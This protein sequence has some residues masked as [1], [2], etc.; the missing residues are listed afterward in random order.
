MCAK[1]EML[2]GVHLKVQICKKDFF[3][4]LP[5]I[6]K[7]FENRH[8]STLLLLM[9]WMG[10]LVY[11]SGKIHSHFNNPYTLQYILEANSIKEKLS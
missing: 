3:E 2:R 8:M 10:H 6:L 11:Y 1:A 7:C 4:F 9:D 5:W